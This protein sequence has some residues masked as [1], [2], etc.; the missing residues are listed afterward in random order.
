MNF[1]IY[2]L[3]VVLAFILGLV[4]AK[5]QNKYAKQSWEKI[6]SMD[7]LIPLIMFLCVVSLFSWIAVVIEI[8]LIFVYVNGKYILKF[9]NSDEKGKK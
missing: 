6:K 1:L 5:F 7:D 2:L 9:L 3:G 8:I 4:V